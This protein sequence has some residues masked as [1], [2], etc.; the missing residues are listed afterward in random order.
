MVGNP[1][2]RLKK[3][4][5]KS[6]WKK[7]P[8]QDPAKPFAARK[9]DAR[10]SKIPFGE[11][12]FWD[13]TARVGKPAANKSYFKKDARYADKPAKPFWEKKRYA[14]NPARE[15]LPYGHPAKSEKKYTDKRPDTKRFGEKPERS[16]G[17]R[18]FWERPARPAG[19]K[20]E[21]Q[22]YGHR[23]K[24]DSAPRSF[25]SGRPSRPWARSWARPGARPQRS[26]RTSSRG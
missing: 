10:K 18:K 8:A 20:P 24:S 25:W 23:T 11:R 13:D 6:S 7:R 17:P 1:I 3:P 12:K 2:H 9:H 21:W 14:E 15:K 19:A 26:S 5:N 22:R 16:F 4:I